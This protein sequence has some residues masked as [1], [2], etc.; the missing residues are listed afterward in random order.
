MPVIQDLARGGR[1]EAVKIAAR[2]PVAPERPKS[3]TRSRISGENHLRGGQAD[4]QIRTG[5]SR[6][7][8]EFN[9]Y[10]LAQQRM[11]GGRYEQGLAQ[12]YRADGRGDGQGCGT[13]RRNGL[14]TVEQRT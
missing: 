9:D 2:Y 11:I 12:G 14:H 7:I 3:A 8:E 10:F 4:R 5:C 6:A 13:I 1:I